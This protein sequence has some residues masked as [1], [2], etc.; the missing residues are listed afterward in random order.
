MGPVAQYRVRDRRR[1]LRY[2][3]VRLP[4]HQ[5]SVNGRPVSA[6]A[7]GAGA[8]HRLPPSPRQWRAAPGHRRASAL[9]AAPSPRL[10][11]SNP[12][13][14]SKNKRPSPP[15]ARAPAINSGRA[16]M[17]AFRGGRMGHDLA[18]RYGDPRARRIRSVLRLAATSLLLAGCPTSAHTS[19]S[20]TGMGSLSG[21]WQGAMSYLGASRPIG[22]TLTEDGGEF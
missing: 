20:S 5:L 15:A 19:G 10:A 3:A 22:F 18:A 12:V 21:S 9:G 2:A 1:T 8:G 6:T 14:R 13:S 7:N 16:N 4:S 11:G 17:V